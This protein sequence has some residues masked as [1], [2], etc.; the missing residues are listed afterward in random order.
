MVTDKCGVEVWW[1]NWCGV[2]VWWCGGMVMCWCGGVLMWWC[3]DV[4][5]GDHVVLAL[6][7]LTLVCRVDDSSHETTMP[8]DHHAPVHV[9]HTHRPCASRGAL[10][11][12]PHLHHLRG[13]F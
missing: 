11:R 6:W 1:C 12:R 8:S 3:I 2:L 4:V 10:A 9:S 5:M 7:T 13:W